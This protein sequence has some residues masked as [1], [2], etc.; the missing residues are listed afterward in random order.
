[1]KKALA[2]A[3][4][5]I[6]SAGFS[7]IKVELE[8]DIGR[9]GERECENCEGRGQDECENCEGEGYV[10]SGDVTRQSG[11]DVLVECDY[12]YGEGTMDCGSCEGTGNSGNYMDEST[13]EEFM[14]D[15]VPEE[16]FNR[17]IYG[18]FYDDGSVDSEFTFTVSIDNVEDVLVWM[19]AF[20]ALADECGNGHIDTEGAGLHITVMPSANYPVNGQ[21]DTLGCENFTSEMTKLLPALFFLASSGH[22]SRDLQ[23]RH[24]SIGDDKYHAISTHDNTCFEFRVFETCYYKPE[25]FYDYIKTIANCLKFYASPEL[26]VKALG[27]KFGF[28]DGDEVARF[29]DTPEQLRILNSTIKH[30]KPKDKTFKKLKEERGVRYTLKG[31]E[32][33]GKVRMAQLRDE[34]RTYRRNWVQA[35]T[36]P[37][38]EREI[39]D[40]DY[41]VLDGMGVAE[42]EER[43]RGTRSNANMMTL[44]EFINNNVA[45]R[46]DEVVTV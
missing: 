41:Y 25:A 31:L 20:K 43:V 7:H 13:C 5:Q 26:K 23:Y 36:R 34:Y 2:E 28:N 40:R 17:L 38:T 1:M 18:N 27:K 15:Y 4:A 14:K 6:K 11:E 35:R 10:A 46:Y 8:G 30:I 12:C 19:D 3:V 44:S 32:Q 29:Y 45:M 9:D 24:A 33:R 42:A 37:L 21:L 39:A 22:R 16:V